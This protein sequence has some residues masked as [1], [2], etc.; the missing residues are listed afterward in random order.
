MKLEKGWAGAE[1]KEKKS[2]FGENTV[3]LGH[4]TWDHMVRRPAKLLC[5]TVIRKVLE[6]QKNA[7]LMARIESHTEHGRTKKRYVKEEKKIHSYPRFHKLYSN[8]HKQI[9]E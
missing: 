6:G 4:V 5:K 1:M 8:F 2:S 7:F 3:F 9:L